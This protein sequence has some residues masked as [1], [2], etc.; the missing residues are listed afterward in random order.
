MYGDVLFFGLP[1]KDCYILSRLRIPGDSVMGTVE[2][3]ENTPNYPNGSIWQEGPLT[4]QVPGLRCLQIIE[5]MHGL[6]LRNE[7]NYKQKSES[8]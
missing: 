7:L 5:K 3:I 8:E 1:L 6:H 2:C 4:K